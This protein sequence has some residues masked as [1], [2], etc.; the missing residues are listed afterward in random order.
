MSSGLAVH[1][2]GVIIFLKTRGT[3]TVSSP[4]NLDKQTAKYVLKKSK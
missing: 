4:A 2:Q 1:G 3:A